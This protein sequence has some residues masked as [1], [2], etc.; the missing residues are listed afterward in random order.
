MSA[1]D[2]IIAQ[3]SEN[4]KRRFIENADGSYSPVVVAGSVAGVGPVD[5]QN[6]PIV[7]AV[8]LQPANDGVQAWLYDANGVP[9]SFSG[10]SMPVLPGSATGVAVPPNAMYVGLQNGSNLTGLSAFSTVSDGSGGGGTLAI[11]QYMSNNATGTTIEKVRNTLTATTHAPASTASSTVTF[12]T[13]NARS[14]II[15]INVSAVTGG[16]LTVTINGRSANL[17]T[18]PIL[19]ASAIATVSLVALRIGPGL[20]PVANLTA[21][22]SL[23]RTVQVVATVTGTITYGIDYILSV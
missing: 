13:Y 2:I 10:G 3:K 8:P 15:L 16:T 20:T 12:V 1:G 11:A 4:L 17:Y 23:P 9:M 18:Y 6:R 5:D 21:N 19:A 22:E 14:A 7:N